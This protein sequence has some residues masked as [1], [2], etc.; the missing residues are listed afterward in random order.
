MASQSSR[1]PDTNPRE[2]VRFYLLDHKTAVGKAIDI[3][4]LSLNLLFVAVFVVETYPHSGATDVWLWRLEVGIAGVFLAE[5]V[6]RIYGAKAR[7]AE[8]TNPYTVIDLLSILPTLSVLMLP[9]VVT[10]EVGFLRVVRVVRVLRFYRF[11]RDEEFFFG[12]VEAQTLRAGKLL[13][14][15]LVLLFATAGLFYSAEH[16]ANPD[17][18]TFGDAFYY[19]VVT[20]TTVG[21][22]DIIPATT[23]GRWVTVS[24]ILAGILLIPWQAGRIVRAWAA[25]DRVDVTCPNC[26]LRRH[27]A[28]ASH[29]KACGHV[30][31]QEYS[32]EG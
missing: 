10:F 32:A 16:I 31:Y 26:G 27:D 29:C 2:V 18:D 22:G 11:T 7:L 19:T 15:V 17:V 23:G 14:T 20:L 4:L 25:R 12:T 5:Y 21:F 3:A 24:A 28:D 1:P 6:L 30:I 13:L 9:G 8:A